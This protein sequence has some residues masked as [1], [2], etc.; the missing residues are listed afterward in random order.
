MEIETQE[1][2]VVK[3]SLEKK[4][5]NWHEVFELTDWFKTDKVKDAKVLVVGSGAIGNEV[6]KNLALMGVGNVL[7]IDFDTV[8]YVNLARSILFREEDCDK[9]LLK[10]EVAARRI[11]EINPNIKTMTINGDIMTDLGYGVYRRM[12]VVIGGLDNRLARW[13]VDQAAYRMQKP[14]VDGA[15]GSMSGLVRVFKPGISSYDSS[16]SPEERKIMSNQLSCR[17]VAMRNLSLGRIPTTPL[18]SSIVGSLQ[19]QE[20]LKIIHG[21]EDSI[22]PYEIEYYGQTN[23]FLVAPKAPV[24]DEEAPCL[25]DIFDDVIEVKE[26]SH[27]NTVK[28]LL[29][30]CKEKFETE[31]ISV[32]LNHEIVTQFITNKTQKKVDVVVAYPKLSNAITDKYTEDD[33]DVYLPQDKKYHELDVEFPYPEKTLAELSIPALHVLRIYANGQIHHIELTGDEDFINFI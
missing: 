14:W 20:A 31:E 22:V 1:N 28:E 16:L 30:W 29:D 11:K 8:E 4:D 32:E 24:L 33:E 5:K 18:A 10:C 3:I 27:K 7:I 6:L 17:D 9:G 25:T 2:N 12:D 15:L 23:D 19:V 21:Y 13:Y 26:L